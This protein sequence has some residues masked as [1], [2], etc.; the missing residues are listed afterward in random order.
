MYYYGVVVSSATSWADVLIYTSEAKPMSD[1]SNVA[2]AL[3]TEEYS[4]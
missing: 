1:V 3:V 2:S 4:R